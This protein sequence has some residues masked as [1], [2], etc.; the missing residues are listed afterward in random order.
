MENFTKLPKSTICQNSIVSFFFTEN[1]E[2]YDPKRFKILWNYWNHKILNKLEFFLFCIVNF[3]N[4]DNI[5]N[6]H[7]IPKTTKLV[8][9]GTFCLLVQIWNKMWNYV[10]PNSTR[11]GKFKKILFKIGKFSKLSK[12]QNLKELK[13]FI[14]LWKIQKLITKFWKILLIFKEKIIIFTFLLF[15]LI[16]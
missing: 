8:R 4:F 6:F 7:W 2:K 16:L 13:L 5:G 14:F 9:I 12:P 10:N 11:I 1:S 3:G 15:W